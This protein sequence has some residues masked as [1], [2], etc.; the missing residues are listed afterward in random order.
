MH[1]AL[2]ISEIVEL[3]CIHSGPDPPSWR[4]HSKK[5]DVANL[6]MTSTLFLDHALDV[7]WQCQNGLANILKCMPEDLWDG[8]IRSGSLD[9]LVNH[10]L[11]KH[12]TLFT[13]SQNAVRPI[14]SA[15]WERPLFYLSRVRKFHGGRSRAMGSN[16]LFMQLCS[17]L[18][19]THW[20]PSLRFLEW[21]C[22]EPVLLPAI[23]ALIAPRTS[24]LRLIGLD[25]RENLSL[26][27]LKVHGG[28]LTDVYIGK[29][30][31]RA[32]GS[33]ANAFRIGITPFIR[34]LERLQR[35]HIEDFDQEAF[36]HLAI[37]PDLKSLKIAELGEL[38]PL[39]SYFQL[40]RAGTFCGLQE[41]EIATQTVRSALAVFTS[42]SGPLTSLNLQIKHWRAPL[43]EVSQLFATLG[44]MQLPLRSLRISI[45]PDIPNYHETMNSALEYL[46][47]FRSLEELSL[48]VGE[49]WDLDDTI[50]FTMARAWPNITK[51]Y[52]RPDPPTHVI[53][54]V[55]LAGLRA[56]ALHCH[57]LSDLS[58]NVDARIL[59]E[60]L[61]ASED[62][63]RALTALHVG[64]SPISNT[65]AVATLLFAMYPQL[66]LIVAEENTTP[67]WRSASIHDDTDGGTDV[68]KLS[69]MFCYGWGR[70]QGMLKQKQ[71]NVTELQL[72]AKSVF[73]K[74]T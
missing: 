58:I 6:A 43:T 21:S 61:P 45:D 29:N 59:F 62:A 33:D 15:D 31:G 37:L 13:E 25:I 28:R 60:D 4:P 65:P 47:V 36:R 39:P 52:M 34:S 72:E 9:A 71:R 38:N 54:R 14:T 44:S 68:Y 55:T 22:Y 40:V 1:T 53:R 67:D 24:E 73:P 3:I 19:T 63:Q 27:T 7:L 2:L 26:L 30:R 10:F 12:E 69:R 56:F 18:P 8:P 16:Q 11:L 23:G 46:F 51:L 74:S 42:I 57:K 49:G 48:E 5:R 35:F 64:Y 50:V 20:F 70:V 66:S 41:L 32:H 17:S